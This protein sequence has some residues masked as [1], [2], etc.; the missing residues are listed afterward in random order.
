MCVVIIKRKKLLFKYVGE[1]WRRERIN[2]CFVSLLLLI[3]LLGEIFFGFLVSKK[4][5]A[6]F[7]FVI[8]FFHVCGYEIVY[9]YTFG[10]VVMFWCVL[11]G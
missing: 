1:G 7:Q 9:E 11:F 4:L 6:I 3:F 5:D 2:V 8:V 10:T